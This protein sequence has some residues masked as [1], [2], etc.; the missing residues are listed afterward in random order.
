MRAALV[1]ALVVLASCGSEGSPAERALRDTEG[2][3]SDIRSGALDMTLLASAADARPGR[4]VGFEMAGRFAV[5][6]QKGSLPVADLEYTRITGDD[7][8]TTRFISTGSAAFVEVDGETYRLGNRQVEGLR[9]R[10]TAEDSGGLDG[11]RL[12]EWVQSPSLA[13]ADGDTDR[14]SGRLDA[15]AAINDI[16]GLAVTLGADDPDVPRRLDGDAAARVRR[17]VRSSGVTLVTGRD[18]RLLRRADITIELSASEQ[19]RLRDAL[20]RFTGVELRFELE[21][22]DA[23][24]PVRVEAP[25]RARP[26]AEITEEGRADR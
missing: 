6:R 13:A 18:D 8:R 25:P 16:L 1:A 14:I 12:G 2:N 20:G 4:G 22:T 17:A 26:A 24:E 23:N 11:L 7:R 19:E 21:V 9:R 5:A 10:D 15:V 3:L